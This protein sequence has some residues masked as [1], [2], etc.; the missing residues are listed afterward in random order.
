MGLAAMPGDPRPRRGRSSGGV[1]LAEAIP[2]LRQLGG[3]KGDLAAGWLEYEYR[4]GTKEMPV[5]KLPQPRWDG[6]P[7][8]GKTILL[9]G[10]QGMGDAIQFIRYAAVVAERGGKVLVECRKELVGL[11]GRCAGIDRIVTLGAALPAFDTHAALMSVPALVGTEL[12][13]IPGG[14]PS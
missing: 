12:A 3:T 5:R 11:F 14:K 8:D 6:S 7:L 13:S 1:R 10:E 9:Y 4:W 2:G